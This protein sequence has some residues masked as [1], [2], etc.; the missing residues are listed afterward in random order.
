M[1]EMHEAAAHAGDDAFRV[2]LQDVLRPLDDPAAIQREAARLLCQRLKANRVLYG[3]VVENGQSVL[4][5]SDYCDGV[6]SIVGRH[7]LDDF[8][9]AEMAEF[10]GGRT[11]VVRD[12][13]QDERLTPDQREATE[14]LAIGAYV[15]APLIKNGL[16]VAAFAVHNTGRR[17]WTHEEISLIEETAERTWAAVER[18]QAEDAL[19]QS[20]EDFVRAQEVGQIGWWRLDTTQNILTW[21]DENYRI[22]GVPAGTPLT[23]ETF[24]DLVHPD[25]RAFVDAKWSAR[26]R[27]EPYDIQHRI[28]SNG[29]VKWVRE[30]AYLELGET[31]ELRGG[32]GITQDISELKQSEEALRDSEERFRAVFEHAGIGIAITNWEGRLVQTNPAYCRL[33]GYTEDELGE[34]V[35]SDLVHPDDREANLAETRRLRDGEQPFFEIENRYV[36]KDGETVWVHKFVSLLH[37]EIG[38]PLHLVALVTD[39]TERRRME[40]ALREADRRKDEFL[41]TLAH[42]LRNPLAPISNALHV[43]QR[44]G[45]PPETERFLAMIHRQ[46]AHL[47][48]LVDDLLEVSRIS[49]GNIELRKEC[50]DLSVVI[51]QAMETSQPLIQAG[52]HEISVSLHPEPLVV[53][54]DPVRLSQIFANLLNNAAKYTP[55]GGRIW[56]NAERLDGEAIVR[57]RDT[58]AG[59]SA[60]MLPRV[61]DLFTQA[62]RHQEGAQAGLG[63]GLALVR[64]LVELHGGRVE[65]RSAGLGEGSE[66]IVRLPLAVGLASGGETAPCEARAPRSSHRVLVID[67]NQDVANSLAMLLE[68][69]DVEVR[70]AYGG[71]AGLDALASFKPDLVILDLGMPGMDGFEVAR[72]IRERPEGRNLLLVALTGW[73]QAEDRGL[74]REAGFDLHLVKPA[75]MEALQ[76]LLVSLE[77]R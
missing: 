46:V 32:F 17:D 21:S 55:V 31:G 2:V 64:S 57:V 18:A 30:K 22:F 26:L 11:L 6:P 41:A 35:F 1:A 12:V 16:P 75:E 15:V 3:Q 19:R 68:T 5:R 51:G 40:D 47:V 45:A 56:L 27:G 54:G 34:F 4:V 73:G 72:R 53:Q 49:R 43:L 61:F 58:G 59:I 69:F 39:V 67:D 24:L 42:E 28:I 8:G 48:R 44:I 63:I 33:V 74:T 9:P 13:A 14:A 65:A 50:V 70:T 25:D 60:E 10:R 38:A 36:R 37:N 66:F 71:P 76:E 7:R 52:R 23:Y 62:D 77:S 29:R 20:R